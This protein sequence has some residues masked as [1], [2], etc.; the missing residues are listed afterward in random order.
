MS[1]AKLSS[2]PGSAFFDRTHR[3]PVDKLAAIVISKGVRFNPGKITC[4]HAEVCPPVSRIRPLTT[5]DLTGTRSGRLAVIGLHAK[6]KGRW[7]VRC[8][9]GAYE[10]RTAKALRNPKNR[11]DR[12]V[13]CWKTAGA[14]KHHAWLTTGREIDA[15]DL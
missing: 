7:V 14:K 11:N 9:C 4:L 12:C 15:R 6:I 8:D 2:A 5:Q 13:E 10:V 1:E 3:E